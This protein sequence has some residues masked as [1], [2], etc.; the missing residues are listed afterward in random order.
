MSNIPLAR[1]RLQKLADRVP[2]IRPAINM[3]MEDLHREPCA[4]KTA[5]S[6]TPM[7]AQLAAAI[8]QYANAHPDMPNQ[9][10]GEHFGVNAGRVSEAIHGL[11]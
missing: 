5:P 11:R 7:T 6:S 10:I 4:R 2:F 3:I 8:R 9:A 1:E